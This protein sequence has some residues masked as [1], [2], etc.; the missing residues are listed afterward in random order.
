MEE[1]FHEV[2]VFFGDFIGVGVGSVSLAG[3]GFFGSD[4]WICIH[5]SIRE[6]L[7]YWI[8]IPALNFKIRHNMSIN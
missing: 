3:V 1:G 6:C 8:A 4:K 7:Q 2:E 5:L